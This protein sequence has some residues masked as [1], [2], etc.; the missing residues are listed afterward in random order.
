MKKLL[1]FFSFFL[2]FNASLDESNID[3]KLITIDSQTFEISWSVNIKDYDE[4]I[5][6]INHY[7][8][9][10]RYQLLT[11]DGSIEMCCYADEV[12]VTILVLV[13]TSIEQDSEEC[14]AVNCYE[15]IKETYFNNKLLSLPTTTT[16][17]TTTTTLPTTT[18]TNIPQVVIA[19]K[20][21]FLNIEITNA[22]ITS[23]PLF[24][25]IDLT[26]QEKNS[27]AVVVS[28]SIIVLFYIVLL[29]QEWFNKIL[30]DNN[31]R[32][33][34][35]D[36]EFIKNSKFKNTLKISFV[37][38]LTS[39]LV[40]YVEEGASFSIDLENIAI[41]IAAFVG[42]A[43]V[44]LFS[45]GTEG[46]IES[47]YL[48]Q[49]VKIKW[50][51][52]A[53]FFAMV[54]TVSFI[55]FNMPIGFI[56]GFVASSYIISQR[57]PAKISPKFFS[58]ISLSLAG[59]GFFYLTSTEF[60]LNSTVITAIASLSYLMCLE[61]V[62]FKS[63]PGGGNELF[64]SLNDSQGAYKILPLVSFI[65]GVWLF[66]RIL[67]ISP[68]SEFANF[69]Q[70]ILGMGSFSITFA[71]MLMIYILGILILGIGVKVFSDNE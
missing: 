35:S 28:T 20:V 3:I 45:E 5:L 8:T 4:I 42:L 24:D 22:L 16:T 66:I 39:F 29:L 53:I 12:E 2:F 62:L 19:E 54:S 36:K 10:E 6:E 40:G 67:I 52:Q 14:P 27:M 9:I 65:I 49:K 63:L 32:W 68:D 11:P 57:S 48:K 37:L 26:D 69:Q 17:S 1:I 41:F 46:F 44:T 50:A 31:I 30:S 64:E 71:I 15:F 60:V 58:S 70:D 25:D 21:D 59:F 51:P 23:I 38:I 56:F 55:Y 34:Q 7:D 33:F 61:G 18:T 47:K 13:T 43:S